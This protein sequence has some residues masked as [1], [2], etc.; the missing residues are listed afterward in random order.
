MLRFLSRVFLRELDDDFFRVLQRPEVG[1]ALIKAD[2]AITEFLAG[3]WS[4]EDQEEAAVEFCRLFIVPGACLPV[5]CAWLER[6]GEGKA[7]APDGAVAGVVRK[8][9][10]SLEFSLGADLKSA[11]PDHI[12]VVLEIAA[13]LEV[14]A[15]AADSREFQSAVLRTWAPPFARELSRVAQ[16]PVYRAAGRLLDEALKWEN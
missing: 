2:P 10:E 7:A 6:T 5:A 9:I 13:W 8:L 14:E 3:E 16:H 4:P 15:D 12:S 11:P 1:E